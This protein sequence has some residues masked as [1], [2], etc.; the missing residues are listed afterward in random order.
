MRPRG[1]NDRPR[2]FAPRG[3][4]HDAPQGDAPAA[5]P[6]K[7]RAERPKYDITCATC[8]A[9][10]QVPFKPLEGRQVFCQACYRARKAP[11]EGETTATSPAEQD[12]NPGGGAGIIE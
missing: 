1:P 5:R 9:E 4:R 11:A 8:G 2:D 12:V 7:A 6:P 3:P 10:A